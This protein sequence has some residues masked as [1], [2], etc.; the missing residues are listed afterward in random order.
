MTLLLLQLT[1]PVHRHW[2]TT[3]PSRPTTSST[4]V[5]V[6][7]RNSHGRQMTSWIL[8]STLLRSLQ[9]TIAYLPQ[10][11]TS[12]MFGQSVKVS[13]SK[14]TLTVPYLR[15]LSKMC[16][17]LPESSLGVTVKS[18]HSTPWKAVVHM[19]SSS[20]L[21][22]AQPSTLKSL[23]LTLRLTHGPLQSKQIILKKLERT[24]FASKCRISSTLKTLELSKTSRFKF[25]IV[26]RPRT[27]SHHRR[28][29]T[30]LTL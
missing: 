15:P 26:A 17:M 7:A 29:P 10:T 1:L 12:W 23:Q 14:L 4:T 16:G 21:N 5:L 18:Q 20:S 27:L 30:S 3:T 22:Q 13:C 8:I 19:S 11:L 28:P 25:R 24:R 2:F 9:L 6:L